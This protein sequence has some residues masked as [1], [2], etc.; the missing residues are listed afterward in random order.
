MSQLLRLCGSPKEKVKEKV[1]S[2][3]CEHVLNML[4]LASANLRGMLPPAC[5][6]THRQ[7]ECSIQACRRCVLLFTHTVSLL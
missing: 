5:P 7:A 1:I 2:G 3:G 4:A 6:A